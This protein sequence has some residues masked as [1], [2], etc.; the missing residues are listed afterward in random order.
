ML[1]RVHNL[2][3]VPSYLHLRPNR[4]RTPDVAAAAA[5]S[6]AAATRAPLRIE[7]SRVRARALDS[8]SIASVFGCS[9][10]FPAEA[11]ATTLGR[12]QPGGPGVGFSFRAAR[13]P[14]PPW[15]EARRLQLQALNPKP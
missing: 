3:G 10:R 9:P 15:V 2:P 7:F 8:C 14:R 5:R 6:T 4:A 11:E 13:R 12:L 1:A